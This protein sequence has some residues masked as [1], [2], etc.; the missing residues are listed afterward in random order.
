MIV[1]GSKGEV[2]VLQA[3]E[4]KHCPVCE[5]ERTFLVQ[6][7]YKVS[8]I[9]Y[10][11]KWVSEKQYVKVCEICQRGEKLATKAVEDEL[12]KPPIPFMSRWGWVFL[13]ALIGVIA[14]FGSIADSNRSGH[15]QQLVASPMKSDIYVVDLASL[16]KSPDARV[17][18]GVLRVKSVNGNDI[19]FDAPRVT[20]NKSKG[21]VKDLSSGKVSS[22]DYFDGTIVFSK[23][24]IARL[25]NA[26]HIYSID[27]N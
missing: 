5:K 10:L 9:W 23:D 12:G 3:Q 26:G 19:E 6:L 7:H 21:A 4:H 17:M 25:Q 15:V 11:F 20:Y 18:Y 13:V 2:E 14:V 22:P 1:W 16:M 24:E 8:H 27:R